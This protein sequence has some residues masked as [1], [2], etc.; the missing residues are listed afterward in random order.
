MTL[1]VTSPAEARAAAPPVRVVVVT[2][3]KHLSGLFA[4]AAE[5]LGRDIPG[6]TLTLHAATD[7]AEDRASLDRCIADIGR[8]DIIIAT[9]L[10][11]EDHVR[12]VL[13]A[14]EARREHCD[15]ILGVM[16]ASE[17]VRLTRL[18]SLKMDGSDK[19]PIA[20][21][22]R[23]RGGAKGK[24]SS[25]A[26]Q[27]AM[28]RRLPKLLRFIPGPAQD[29]R[30]YFLTMQY[31]LCG[32][33]SQCQRHGPLPGRPLRRRSAP[34]AAGQGRGLSAARLPGDR[35]LPPPGAG[36]DRRNIGRAGGC[37]S[38]FPLD[39]GRVGDGGE[40]TTSAEECRRRLP[41][42]FRQAQR[43]HPHPCPSPIEGE[44][45]CWVFKRWRG[46]HGRRAGA[47][48]LRAGRG[49]RPL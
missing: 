44:R 29:L 24:K 26:G 49:H 40:C 28:L 17:I 21:L 25:G 12:A 23:L 6:L 46:R 18:G 4:R 14:L 13:P 1:A 30:A 33:G 9:M 27:M 5:V 15:A 48:L 45:D 10:F 42:P 38:P 32:L 39:G 31:W 19:G 7:W 47:A 11:M 3:D 8:G 43:E 36:P 20:M 22:K 41:S 16:S 2:L 35:A 37:Q 34:R